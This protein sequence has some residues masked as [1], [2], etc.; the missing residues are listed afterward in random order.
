MKVTLDV[1]TANSVDSTAS[2]DS[3]KQINGMLEVVFCLIRGM[4]S[5][6]RSI[7]SNGTDVDTY[8]KLISDLADGLKKTSSEIKDLIKRIGELNS[9]DSDFAKKAA[10]LGGKLKDLLIKLTDDEVALSLNKVNLGVLQNI[11][12]KGLSSALKAL[13]EETSSLEGKYV[14][15]I[16]FR[17]RG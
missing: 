16:K 7:D 9:N 17:G 11:S 8:G 6:G 2:S 1:K 5:V 12:L 10:N 4:E 15:S 14:N 3:K 13:I